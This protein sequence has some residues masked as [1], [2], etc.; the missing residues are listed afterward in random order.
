MRKAAHTLLAVLIASCVPV[1]ATVPAPTPS[2][3][4]SIIVLP[5]SSATPYAMV[6]PTATLSEEAERAFIAAT[7]VSAPGATVGPPNASPD[8]DWVAEVVRHDCTPVA[9][10]DQGIYA[11]ELLQ[12]RNPATSET[13]VVE[14]QLQSCGGLGAAGLS[15][16]SWSRNGRY[17]YYTEAASGI[18]EGCGWWIPP[19]KRLDV[20]TWSI[21]DLGSGPLSPDGRMRATWQRS[22]LLLSSVEEGDTAHLD[23]IDHDM[24]LGEIA[25]SPDSTHLVYLQTELDCYPWGKTLLAY[26]DLAERFSRLLLTSTSPSFAWVEW[27]DR[28]QLRLR[29]QDD[30]QWTY[31]LA[32]GDLFVSK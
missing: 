28:T 22:T 23:P 30:V 19:V 8:G 14:T 2:P 11:L 9:I 29:D 1:H 12:L 25:W 26:V 13:K 7:L 32:A 5:A 6:P 3:A 16:G 4:A 21:D 20:S 17:L 10:V 15:A 27:N 18:P 31:D 24:I